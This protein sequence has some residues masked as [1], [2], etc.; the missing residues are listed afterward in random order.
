MRFTCL[1]AVVMFASGAI[2]AADKQ[3]PGEDK[4]AGQKKSERAE[5]GFVK[6]FDGHSLKGWQGVDGSTDSYCVEDGVLICKAEGR[7]HIFTEKE[8][9]NFVL[10]LDIKIDPDGNNGVGIRTDVSKQP[11]LFGMELQV[12]DNVS[13][14]EKERK[15]YQFH[16]SIYGVVPAKQGAQKPPGEWNEQEVV[17]NGRQVKVTLNGKVIV[18]VDLDTITEPTMDGKD[19][20]GLKY[21]KGHIGLHAHGQG[22]RVFFRNMRIKEL[23]DVDADK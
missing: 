4:K 23:P 13:A 15:P 17:C 5:P 9:A 1:V 19:H 21:T 8:Y 14:R 7:Q 20:P 2:R 11:H 16:G 6:I 3:P 22:A 18:D 10:R 12:I